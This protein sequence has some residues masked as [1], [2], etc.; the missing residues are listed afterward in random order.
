MAKTKRKLK[1][2][3]SVSTGRKP[4]KAQDERGRENRNFIIWT[5]VIPVVMMLVILV[6]SLLR[7]WG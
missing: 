5:V 2:G 1:I 3:Q 7:V 6:L 4:A